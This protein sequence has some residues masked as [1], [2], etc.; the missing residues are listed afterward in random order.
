[1]VIGLDQIQ[2]QKGKKESEIRSDHG[3]QS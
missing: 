3:I 2:I 1:L